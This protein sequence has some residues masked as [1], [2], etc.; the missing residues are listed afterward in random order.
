MIPG[1]P[2]RLQNEMKKLSSSTSRIR[3]LVQPDRSHAV[4]IGG[5]ILAS[6][7]AFQKAYIS[8]LD[9]NE[10]GPSII[11]RTCCF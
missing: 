4:W 7:P 6:F 8:K 5:S 10:Y 3:F 11:H 9:Y 1:L 2:D